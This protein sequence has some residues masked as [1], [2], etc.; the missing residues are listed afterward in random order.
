[1]INKLVFCCLFY[2]VFEKESYLFIV[3]CWDGSDRF[4]F[5]V[6]CLFSDSDLWDVCDFPIIPSWPWVSVFKC[7]IL[8]YLVKESLMFDVYLLISMTQ[9]QVLEG[10]FCRSMGSPKRLFKIVCQFFF[11]YG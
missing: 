8:L 7:W 3:L 9:V 6:S 2:V 4:F 5:S 11:N 10:L 1:M